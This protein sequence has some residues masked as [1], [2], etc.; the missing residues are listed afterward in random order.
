MSHNELKAI[1]DR[2]TAPDRRFLLAYLRSKEPDY[3]GKLSA[4]D[5]ELDKGRGV[6]LRAT[7]HGLVRMREVRLRRLSA[8]SR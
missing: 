5:R 3:R 6:R 8:S 1:V 7:R 4:V 2:C